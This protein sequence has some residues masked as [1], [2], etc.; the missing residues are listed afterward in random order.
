M[1]CDNLACLTDDGCVEAFANGAV[2]SGLVV[3]ADGLPA[4]TVRNTNLAIAGTT[5]TYTRY[6]GTTA[7]FDVCTDIVSKCAINSLT[8]V[9]T[10]TV[11][12]TA[13]NVLA[14]DGA[15]WV[16]ASICSLL[17]D[18]SMNAL[19]DV[20]TQTVPPVIGDVLSWDGTNWIPQVNTSACPALN[21]IVADDC[22]LGGIGNNYMI[23]RIN[24]NQA[25]CNVSIDS[26]AEHT[27]ASAAGEVPFRG[28]VVPDGSTTLMQTLSVTLTNPSACRSMEY[29][30]F[31]RVGRTSV[32]IPPGNRWFFETTQTGPGVLA[33][34]SISRFDSRIG[35][36]FNTGVPEGVQVYRG[37]IAPAGTVT[38]SVDIFFR[39]DDFV[40]T[41][42]L[43][44][45]GVG[46]SDIV[47]FGSTV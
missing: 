47:I 4:W 19:S 43:G 42:P 46:Q 8:D 39:V 22:V 41:N 36:P 30:A 11:A 9:D 10:V 45:R 7:V 12:P 27:S 37:T 2:G 34:G 29:V 26:A 33:T 25:T 1:A 5:M 17:T 14:W 23:K 13:T 28:E 44:R 40:P 3:G 18:C 16:P 6:D 21:F 15:N 35:G 24:F 20:D 38:Y 32:T 31:I